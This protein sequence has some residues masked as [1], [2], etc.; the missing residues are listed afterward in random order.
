MQSVCLEC[1]EMLLQEQ[2]PEVFILV[3]GASLS[4]V[5]RVLWRGEISTA[6]LLLAGVTLAATVFAIAW[7][8]E[9]RVAG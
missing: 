3:I 7:T 2:E 6:H 1:I 8:N 9:C 4:V 5:E